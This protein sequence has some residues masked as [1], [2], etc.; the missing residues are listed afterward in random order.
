MSA[1]TL[2]IFAI[3]FMLIDHIGLAFIHTLGVIGLDDAYYVMRAVGRL[4]MPLFAFLIA[5][6]FRHTRSVPKYAIRL[7]TFALV[8]EVPYDLLTSDRVTLFELNGILPDIHLD[9]V[10]FTLLIGLVFLWLNDFY[11]KRQIKYANSLSV[12]TFFF[13]A[14]LAAFIS[15]DYGMIGVGLVAL[16]G[17]YDISDKNNI[18]KL[19]I[20]FSF[21]EYWKLIARCILAVVYRFLG[22]N[23]LRIP[24]IMYLFS[25]YHPTM[26][27]IQTVALLSF[28]FMLLYNQKSGMPKSRV[29]RTI[30]KYLFYIFYPIHLL[31]LYFVS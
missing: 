9:N 23:L 6:G 19:F 26:A 17:I 16:F 3:I 4:S 24:G 12:V 25:G 5:N 30:L 20:G 13:L 21:L 7:L 29:A 28:G 15:A 22:I 11:K 27:L 2:K 8:S 18:P 10:F 31:I 14:F 1:L